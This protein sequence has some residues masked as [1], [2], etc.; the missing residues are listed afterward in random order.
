MAE[1]ENGSSTDVFTKI[2]T[3]LRTMSLRK[4]A[5]I[6][7]EEKPLHPRPEP[8][9]FARRDSGPDVL[10]S[11]RSSSEHASNCSNKDVHLAKETH[12]ANEAED[13][14]GNKM[15][16]E[17]VKEYK[18]GSG[19]YAKVVLHR[20]VENNQLYAIK[21]FRRS[22]LRKM[23]VA[24]KTNALQDVM[25]EV[26]IM[27]Q[28]NHPNIVRLEEV[29]D[30]P[31]VDKLYMVLEFVPGGSVFEG[32]G[33]NGGLGEDLSRR[34]FRD[35]VAGLM[36]LHEHNV[37]HGDIKP[38]N[39][40]V[41]EEGKIK[42]ADFGVSHMFADSND[43][44]RRSPGTPMF[45][46]PESCVGEVYGGKG[47]DVWALGCTLYIL[48]TGSFP[49]SGA[50]ITDIYNNILKEEVTYPDH[51]SAEAVDLLQGLL[52]KDP[53]K[54]L[55]LLKVGVHKWVTLGFPPIVPL[56]CD[57]IKVN[58]EDIQQAFSS[59]YKA[60]TSSFLAA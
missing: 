20:N 36:Y 34:Y 39:L 31:D 58:K 3:F 14:K 35:T 44:L 26:A 11:V 32:T 6:I 37:V 52:E 16:N 24:P 10:Y 25:H 15:V 41:S 55:T 4:A 59:S 27:K 57:A 48:L 33:P 46:A 13:T 9:N 19:S 1:G 12:I 23:K 54:R 60:P 17:Y 8:L 2:G 40:L 22:R 18:I 56:P 47:A 21:I 42:I 53:K 38:E 5:P 51:L 43:E 28:L 30:D 50:T 49:F 29:I 45:T 7:Q